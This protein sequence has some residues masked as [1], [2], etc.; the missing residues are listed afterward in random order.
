M[1]IANPL[2]TRPHH[3]SASKNFIEV[4]SRYC[5]EH[6]GRITSADDH[7]RR[8]PSIAELL[9]S[10]LLQ[11]LPLALARCPVTLELHD[12][13][14]RAVAV[15]E[16]VEL[17]GYL[18]R[19]DVALAAQ[20]SQLAHREHEVVLYLALRPTAHRITP[21]LRAVMNLRIRATCGD[22]DLNPDSA[23]HIC[24]ALARHRGHLT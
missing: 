6:P 23:V 15:E 3:A 10:V 11:L 19:R 5:F 18:F 8:E 2:R 1:I 4:L 21:I 12:A 7:V 13:D 14:L 16:P 17:A 20:P 24:P 22:G 9:A